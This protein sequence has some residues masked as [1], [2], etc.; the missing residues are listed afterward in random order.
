M[1]F[2]NHV[3][4]VYLLALNAR[5]LGV[6]GIEKLP[7]ATPPPQVS[8]PVEAPPVKAPPVV[9]EVDAPVEAPAE[10]PAEAPTQPEPSIEPVQAATRSS[11]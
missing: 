9:A 8:P 1:L 5:V 10:A 2:I 11:T 7:D 6:L 4:T 3:P